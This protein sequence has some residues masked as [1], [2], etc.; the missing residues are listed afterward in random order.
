MLKAQQQVLEA[1]H[2]CE[3]SHWDGGCVGGGGGGGGL[4]GGGGGG[5]AG[6][7]GWVPS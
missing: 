1:G 6:L 4:G 7:E 3:L 2:E 5:G